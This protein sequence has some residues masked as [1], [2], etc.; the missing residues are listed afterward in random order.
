[1]KNEWIELAQRCLASEAEAVH[2]VEQ[3]IDNLPF[4]IAVN[5]VVSCHGSVVTTGVGKSGLIARRGAAILTSLGVSSHFVH[6]TDALHGD[7]GFIRSGDVV[8]ALSHSGETAEL[9]HLLEHIKDRVYTISITS[10]LWST[11]HKLSDLILLYD[12]RPDGGTHGFLPTV[13]C[14]AQTAYLDSLAVA[15]A[16][17][18]QV[19][20]AAFKLHHPGGSLG[21]T[22]T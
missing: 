11:L 13:S 1:M 18:K 6:P 17:T 21:K 4:E 5:A 7:C 8:I 19:D 14:A 16:T 20:P 3:R 12:K 9:N 15:V 10:G 22:L 2:E